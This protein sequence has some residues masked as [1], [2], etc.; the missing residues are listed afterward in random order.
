MEI[1]DIKSFIEVAN[2]GSFTKAAEHSYLS[3]PS[4]SKSIK[5]LEEELKVKLFDRTTRHLLMTDAGRIVYRQGQ[6]ILSLSNELPSMLEELSDVA[7]GEIKMGIPPLIGTLYFPHI[8]RTFN[9]LYPNVKLELIELG[10]KSIEHLVEENRIDVGLI[11]LPADPSIFNIYPVI[12]DEFLLYIHQ[13]HPLAIQEAISLS[14]LK[15]EQF[16]L[17]AKDF[18]LHDYII[19]TCKE[20]GFSP[21]ISYESSQWDLILELV[22]SKLGITLMP[23]S[24]FEKQ[25]NPKIKALPIEEPDMIWKLGIVTKKNAYHSYALKK[26]LEL[27]TANPGFF[28]LK[29]PEESKNEKLQVLV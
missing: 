11:V 15:D 17:F 9:E 20:A 8:A 24:I 28:G 18:A 1:R 5:K 3:Q 4:L 23:K 29:N 14:D 13:D 10:A 22:A 27:L 6:Q 16:I 26:F 21:V 7:T 25:S 12:N 19:N 2:H